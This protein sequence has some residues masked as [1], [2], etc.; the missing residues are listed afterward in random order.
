M[1]FW[2]Y[3]ALN[4]VVNHNVYSNLY[5]R[6]H[7]LEV[8]EKDRSLVTNIFY[9]TIQNYSYCHEAWKRYAQRKVN[10]K[11]SVL[12]TMSTYQI[13]FLN[14][15]PKYAIINDAVDIAKKIDIKSSGFV[16]AILRKVKPI[17]DVDMALKYSI[18]EWLYRMWITQYGLE[19][20]NC[21]IQSSIS[22][23]PMYVR[24]NQTKI[25][26][27]DFLECPDFIKQ[28]EL[29][30]FKGNDYIHHEFY[31]KGY[32]SAQD[33]GSYQI[34]KFMGCKDGDEVLDCCA[35]PGTKSM[36]MAELMHN[37]GHIDSLDLY[38]HRVNLIENDAKRLGLDIISS[39]VQDS[40]QLEEYGMYD[41][42]LCDVPCTGYGVLSR[43]PDIKL[44]M[45]SSDMDGIIP[46]QYKILISACDHV[47]CGGTLVYSTCT[48]NKKEN[49]KQ[50]E[51]FL[52]NRNDFEKMEEV[53]IFPSE[54]Q[55][56][57]YMV[58][59]RRK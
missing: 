41:K 14:R 20:A 2:V 28:D 52:E 24:R 50:I 38:E 37:I 51:K 57:F 45:K 5:L 56:G 49:E 9:G 23:L 33:I 30:I 16:N 3:N 27:V 6:K 7:L 25:N 11:I 46:L 21:M 15:V 48:M 10:K 54:K 44:H 8:E 13:I 17:E 55:D 34:A 31:K 59:L 43:K 4:E 58:K 32:M 12:L 36:A 22:T 26:E 1:R 39:H 35:A 47:K 29:Y 19:Q 42:V 53:S 40:T 18:P